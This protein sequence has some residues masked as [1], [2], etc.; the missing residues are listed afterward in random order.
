MAAGKDDI[1]RGGGIG[2]SVMSFPNSAGKSKGIV[3]SKH[4]C[5][6]HVWAWGIDFP[7]CFVHD[8]QTLAACK[9]PDRCNSRDIRREGEI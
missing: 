3:D 2:S 1:F 6:I 5:S 9:Q 7:V 8:L 4:K